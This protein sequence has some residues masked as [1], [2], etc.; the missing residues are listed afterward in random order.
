MLT[1]GYSTIVGSKP[2]DGPVL[3]RA[4][5]EAQLVDRLDGAT[6]ISDV[7]ELG[8]ARAGPHAP[9]FGS[10]FRADGS[11]GPFAWQSYAQVAARIAHFALGVQSMQLVPPAPSADTLRALGFFARN[12]AEWVIGALACYRLGIVVV[13][14]YDTLGPETVQFIAA[15]TGASAIL[16]YPSGLATVLAVGRGAGGPIRA[17]VLL[18]PPTDAQTAAATA[19][20]V[21]LHL[22]A[23]VEARGA[24]T[25]GRAG[26]A[27]AESL[28]PRKP[29]GGSLALLCY[30]SGTT[31]EPKGAM[32]S[33]RS[34]L[35][36]V[37]SATLVGLGEPPDGATDWYLSYLPL[38]HIFETAVLAGNLANGCAVGF[39]QGD[40]LKLVDDIAALRPTLFISVPRLYSRI[41]DKILSGV[42]A[43]GALARALFERALSS[44]LAA[45]A[46]T[47]ERAH[48][49]WDR[50]VFNKVRAQ[51][52]L[53]RCRL[54]V[55][56]AAPI[57]SSVKAFTQ[58]VFG[59]PLAEGFGQT[60][61]CAAGTLV[62]VSDFS[63]GHVGPPVPAVEIKLEV[64]AAPRRRARPPPR[65]RA[66]TPLETRP[67]DRPP[68]RRAGPP[69]ARFPLR[70]S[71]R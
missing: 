8:M 44:K 48:P 4:G 20:G 51:L 1:L 61:S 13:P 33:H 70:T 27:P 11:V 34:I 69:R 31:G 40:T 24:A 22:F 14:M 60:E 56:G 2:G 52:G 57:S 66:A 5:Y 30:T 38:A 28:L 9:C 15:Q 39:S 41:H 53:D 35:A 6:I 59:C 68:L 19:A 62:D 16:C 10:R 36:S 71:P 47:G 58:V 12:S 49:L 25:L 55:T 45:L 63:D 3:R 23:D 37:A 21:A 65:T 7:F 18:S 42:A 54:M 64:R 43:K 17:A 26:G 50:L 46:Q 67:A 32:L 29:D